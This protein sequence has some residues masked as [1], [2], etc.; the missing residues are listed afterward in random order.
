[1]VK[2]NSLRGEKW[3]DGDI[4]YVILTEDTFDEIKFTMTNDNTFIIR[5]DEAC[6]DGYVM[7]WSTD[8]VSFDGKRKAACRCK[9]SAKAIRDPERSDFD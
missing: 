4:D 7:A 5:A 8:A 6:V 9:S 2:A 1:V 3:I